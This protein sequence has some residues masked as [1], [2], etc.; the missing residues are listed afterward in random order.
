MNSVRLINLRAT[1]VFETIQFD[2]VTDRVPCK[3]GLNALNDPQ[4]HRILYIWESYD[5]IVIFQCVQDLVFLRIRGS[6]SCQNNWTI[7]ILFFIHPVYNLTNQ[8]ISLCYH[9]E[10]NWIVHKWRKYIQLPTFIVA[11]RVVNGF[12]ISVNTLCISFLRQ[13]LVTQLKNFWFDVLC[14][15]SF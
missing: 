3:M 13:I 2:I 12:R 9:R 14:R 11:N 5:V 8:K 6:Q 15:C 4:R 1:L 10:F 7:D